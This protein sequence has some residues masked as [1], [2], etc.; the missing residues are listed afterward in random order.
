MNT[1]TTTTETNSIRKCA[2]D[3]GQDV[4]GKATFR[5]GHDARLV[6]N[7]V[8]D[9]VKAEWRGQYVEGIF[10]DQGLDASVIDADI[11]EAIDTVA[12]ATEK[13]F[14]ARLAI[15]L[16]IA[17]HNAWDKAVRSTKGHEQPVDAAI[18]VVEGTVKIGRWEYPARK[19]GAK[20]ERAVDR[21]N[22]QADGWIAVPDTIP[23]K[24]A[25]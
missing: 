21:K 23:F 16:D 5:Q 2:C 9:V 6:S 14:S 19:V 17:L 10:A 18:E 15:K 1:T 12:A 7:L 8:K 13:R 25:V 24:P 4:A 22:P 3:C 20:V 11:Q